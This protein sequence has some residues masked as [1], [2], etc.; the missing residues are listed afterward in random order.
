MDRRC[1]RVR[2]WRAV[3]A[4]MLLALLSSPG[5]SL[6]G[7]SAPALMAPEAPLPGSPRPDGA[8]D[9]R[10][11]GQ[12]G[13]PVMSV[14]LQGAYAYINVGSRLVTVDVTEV[15][16]PRQVGRSGLLPGRLWDIV[17]GED[18]LG[19]RTA[20]VAAAES[21]LRIV[22]VS[23]P[24]APREIGALDTPGLARSVAIQDSAPARRIAYIADDAGGLRLIDVADPTAPRELGALA[25]PD[26]AYGVTVVGPLAYV[27]A[28]AS[29]LRVI[30]ISDPRMPREV[31]S[32]DTPGYAYQVA[33]A[34]GVAYVTDGFSGV[35]VVDVSTPTAPRLVGNLQASFAFGIAIVGDLLEVGLGPPYKD[36]LGGLFVYDISDPTAAQFVAGVR[37]PRFAEDVAGAANM[38]FVAGGAEGLRAFDVLHPDGIR[39]VGACE[40]IYSPLDVEVA[41]QSPGTRIAYVADSDTGLWSVDVS[42]PLDPH[43]LGRIAMRKAANVFVAERSPAEGM[44]GA[45]T[46]MAYVA[47]Y[48]FGMRLVDVTDPAAPR[49]V[50]AYLVPSGVLD[51]AAEDQLA[52]VMTWNGL[53]VVDVSDPTRPQKVGEYEDPACTFYGMALQ[54]SPSGRIA[55]L[56]GW[57]AGIWVMDLSDPAAPSV[58]GRFDLPETPWAVAVPDSGAPGSLLYAAD[59]SEGLRIIDVSDPTTPREIG[60]L[61]VT[62]RALDVAVEGDLVYVVDGSFGLRVI[63]ASNPAAPQEVASYQSPFASSAVSVEQG[64]VY[65]SNGRLSVLRYPPLPARLWLPLVLR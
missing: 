51:V 41:E 60:S 17:V 65:L 6:A 58:L 64:L 35:Q 10:L 44:A 25:A 40:T 24:E 7:A 36:L 52:Y 43:P 15:G 61:G 56:A 19:S 9:A 4:L 62:D 39:E 2:F 8:T 42:N 14:A 16:E 34:K 22:D 38:A 20:Y 21:G 29:G 28:G 33:V 54:S 63:D 32:C 1:S 30:D 57:P 26:V 18:A 13:G 12:F 3:S 55:Y 53:H 23:N 37:G 27:A 47:A 49:E 48:Q 46:R 5:N 45:A 11:L 31:G 59:D 50:G